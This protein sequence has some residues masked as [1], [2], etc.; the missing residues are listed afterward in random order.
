[1]KETV[2]MPIGDVIPYEN[3]PRHNKE[4]VAKVAASLREFG[5][6]QPI[7]VDKNNVIVVGHTRL[8]AAKK[9]KMKEVP[10]LVADDL[11]E[12]Q[13]KAYRLAD[14]KTAEFAKWDDDLL[15]VELDGIAEIDMSEFG[16]DLDLD[17]EEESEDDADIEEDDVTDDVESRC[18]IGDMWQLGEHRLI[19]GNS[20]DAGTIGRLM[21]D[22]SQANLL[23]TDPPYG[24]NAD[25]GIKTTYGSNAHNEYKY[26]GEWD[27]ETPS[28]EAFDLMRKVADEQIIFGANY[29]T[30]KLPVGTS[31]IVWDKVGDIQFNNPFSDCE[32]AWTSLDRV[33]T[34]KYTCIQQGFVADE[35]EKRVHPTQKPVKMLADILKDF[36][37]AGDVIIDLF[38]GSGSTLIACERLGRKCLMCELSEHYCDVIINKWE[39]LTG[40]EAVLLDVEQTDEAEPSDVSALPFD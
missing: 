15:Q 11:T 23:L 35:K 12:E 16:F 3:N 36:S 40:Q 2:M 28:K 31:W 19:C 10:V 14:N 7:V 25:K 30:D 8:Q 34:K 20:T 1:M 27:A 6:R 33:I 18:H 21:G 17:D 26:E 4:A 22:I 38:G 39:T 29:F 9:L 37:S 13:I 24:I 32:L 5:F